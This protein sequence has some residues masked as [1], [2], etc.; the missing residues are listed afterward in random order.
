MRHYRLTA[1]AEESFVVGDASLQLRNLGP[2]RQQRCE[3]VSIAQ[4]DSGAA[5]VQDGGQ[6]AALQPNV[7]R[8]QHRTDQRNGEVCFQRQDSVARQHGNPVS[9]RDP[10]LLQGRAKGIYTPLHLG[11]GETPVAVHGGRAIAICDGVA[12]EKLQRSEG[13]YHECRLA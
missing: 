11:V 8:D 4:Q 12:A 3:E 10:G 2:R 13:R 7:E 5:V 9:G 1:L 6:L